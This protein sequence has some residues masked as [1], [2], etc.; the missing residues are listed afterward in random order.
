MLVQPK[1]SLLGA[2]RTFGLGH[3]PTVAASSV[4]GFPLLMIAAEA[5]ASCFPECG[6]TNDDLT[7]VSSWGASG[8]PPHPRDAKTKSSIQMRQDPIHLGS[9]ARA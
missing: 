7:A 3:Q 2:L 4:A 8:A 6:S 5:T 1:L 9:I